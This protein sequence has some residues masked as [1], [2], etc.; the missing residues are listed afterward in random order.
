VS[1]TSR[2][3]DALGLLRAQ[4]ADDA[5][6]HLAT[7][8][9][10]EPPEP[11]AL[12]VAINALISLDRVAEAW[13]H[14][15][16]LRGCATI[17]DGLARVGSRLAN[18]HGATLEQEGLG[19]A[20]LSLYQTA[21]DL[22]PD[23]PDARANLHRLDQ[24][25]ASPHAVMTTVVRST[26]DDVAGTLLQREHDTPD[27]PIRHP[28]VSPLALADRFALPMVY[29]DTNELSAWRA[30]VH[31]QLDSLDGPPKGTPNQDG[32]KS[33]AWSNFLLAYQGEDDLVFQSRYGDWVSA[34]AAALRPDLA[35]PLPNRKPGPNRIGLVSAH[36]YR[37]T[38]G[39]YFASWINALAGTDLT[40]DV[41][42]MAPQIDDFTHAI[43]LP[44]ARLVPLEADAD[45]AAET[46][47]AGDYDL[48]IYPELGIDT[49]LLPI[50]A[51]PLARQQWMAWGHPVTSGLPTVSHYLTVAAMESPKAQDHYRESLLLL[52]GIGTDYRAPDPVAPMSRAALGLPDGPL[53]VCPQSPFK[54][55]PDQDTL[56]A[57]ALAATPGSRLLL[58]A[59]ER[60]AALAKLRARL[61][62]HLNQQGIDPARVIVHPMTTRPRFLQLLAACDVMLDTRHWS[63]GN[64]ALDALFVGLP[65]VAVESAFMRSR[66]SAAMLRFA[67][68]DGAI[69]GSPEAYGTIAR[70]LLGTDRAPWTRAFAAATADR[71][72]LEALRAHVLTGLA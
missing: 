60:P 15:E 44:P 26:L 23:N 14:F 10:Q 4:R 64:T 37:S 40:I 5:L 33:L 69:A 58:F 51:L 62:A 34:T 48:L 29:G 20:A 65:I 46:I 18:R 16:R 72:A 67:D 30:R 27:T 17:D 9:D 59:S 54:I 68:F 7:L 19:L 24:A 36:W 25:L 57:S 12:K 42:S 53:F 71:G 61:G 13:R 31:Q 38:V 35:Q 63:G 70:A 55:H 22:W 21:I 56:L 47:H 49:R 1:G 41:L 50:A 52:P 3:T 45:R 32:L 2:V 6:A 43:T 39:S 8:L 28:G 11:N 66:Q